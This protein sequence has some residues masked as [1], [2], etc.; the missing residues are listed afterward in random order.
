MTQTLVF[1][2]DRTGRLQTAWW[3]DGS[4]KHWSRPPASSAGTPLPKEIPSV[5]NAV[6][7]TKIP[8]SAIGGGFNG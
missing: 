6:G 3:S 2:L 7:I 8:M 4:P 1:A 5:G